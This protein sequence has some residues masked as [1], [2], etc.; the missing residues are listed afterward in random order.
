MKKLRTII[1][2]LLAVS[3]LGAVVTASASAETTLLAEW[4]VGGAAIAVGVEE[5]TTT[6]AEITIEDT[7]AMI[8]VLCTMILDGN[9][10]SNGLDLINK[11]LHL[12][13]EEVTELGGALPLTGTSDTGPDCVTV[14]NCA[15]GTEAS[16]IK[17]WPLGLPWHTLLYLSESG[18][19][20][21]RIS[22]ENGTTAGYELECLVAGIAVTDT[23]ESAGN[24]STVVNDGDTGDAAFLSGIESEELPLDKCSLFGGE[25]G[26]IFYDTLTEVKLTSGLLLTVSSE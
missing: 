23:C 7:A 10:Q 16:P 9:V 15:L 13:G 3:A 24:E 5:A 17:V 14:E 12:N 26:R 1:S 25:T 4:L 11:I 2:A 6:E 22:K 19:F 8:A 18:A 21:D 20:L